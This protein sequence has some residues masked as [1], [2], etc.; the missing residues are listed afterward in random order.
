M[1]QI[2][3]LKQWVSESKRIVAFTGAGVS[4]E[5]G[6]A[7]F[8]SVD[9]LY[10]Q[11]FEYPP[12]TIISHSFYARRPEYF[13]N[14]YREKMMPLGFEPNITHQVLARWEQEGRLSAVVT[15]NIDGL[16]QKAGS[17]NVLEL[18]GSVLRNFCVR[19]G[20]FYDAQYVK[21]ALGVPRCACGGIVKPD[22][23]LYEESLDADTI[24][25]SI[26]AIASADLLIVAGTSL[27]VY[28]AAGFIQYYRGNRLVLINRDE[29]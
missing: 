14:F 21:N 25:R 2:E 27:T 19:C 7:D 8:R 4:T 23:V 20:E 6:I 24:E 28:P 22:V 29:T 3:I 9:G 10:R 16:H 5:S 18:H 1:E 13:F 15:Q 26:E 12:E 11:K 17:Q